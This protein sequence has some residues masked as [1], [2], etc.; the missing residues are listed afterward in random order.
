MQI[1][2]PE[3]QSL[4]RQVLKCHMHRKGIRRTVPTVPGV[5][6]SRPQDANSTLPK[7]AAAGVSCY[8]YS[9]W[10]VETLGISDRGNFYLLHLL[11]EMV[12]FKRLNFLLRHTSPTHPICL[13]K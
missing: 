5:G 13:L 10:W 9:L 7:V 11:G 12:A 1:S 6:L 4:K 3:L 2:C 8:Y